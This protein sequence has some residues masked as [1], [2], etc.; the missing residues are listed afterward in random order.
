MRCQAALTC[1]WCPSSMPTAREA[2]A[3]GWLRDLHDYRFNYG[4]WG[5]QPWRFLCLDCQQEA[6]ASA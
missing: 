4:L 1:A 6:M 2:V 3:A 5:T